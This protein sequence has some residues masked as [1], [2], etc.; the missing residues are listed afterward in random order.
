MNAA[1]GDNGYDIGAYEYSYSDSACAWGSTPHTASHSPEKNSTGFVKDDPIIVH[2]QKGAEN[3]TRSSI[4]MR[5]N[6]QR[7]Y[8]NITPTTDIATEYILTFNHA[9]FNPGPV[10][11][12][13]SAEDT[14]NPTPCTVNETYS[15]T[16]GGAW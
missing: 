4:V 8:P 11:V 6:G 10:S 14:C 16:V 3:I 5:V 7:V 9:T 1:T 13:I 2:I 12:S 15:Y